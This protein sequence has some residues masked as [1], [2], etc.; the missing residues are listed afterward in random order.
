MIILLYFIFPL[1][2]NWSH[3]IVVRIDDYHLWQFGKKKTHLRSLLC[4]TSLHFL[5]Q[6]NSNCK[7]LK[8]LQNGLSIEDNTKK[9]QGFN[10]ILSF[11]NSL[12]S[13]ICFLLLCFCQIGL[14]IWRKKIII[15][16]IFLVGIY[17]FLFLIKFEWTKNTLPYICFVSLFFSFYRSS[18]QKLDKMSI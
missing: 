8:P 3:F 5:S 17:R 2:S 14:N 1:D 12:N 6:S 10:F 13:V 16:H 4:P 15:P 18:R 11:S 9:N 7:W